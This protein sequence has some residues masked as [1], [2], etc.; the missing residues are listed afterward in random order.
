MRRR[1]SQLNAEAVA[2]LRAEPTIR[3]E[4]IEIRTEN[5]VLVVRS[6]RHLRCCIALP[7][8]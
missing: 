7:P 4:R 8:I 1:D 6:L 3:H 5:G 2:E